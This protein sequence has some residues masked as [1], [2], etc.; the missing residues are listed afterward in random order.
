MTLQLHKRTRTTTT[1]TL[2][3]TNTLK[4]PR[5]YYI[6]G[7]MLLFSLTYTN[8]AT[9]PTLVEDAPFTLINKLR[10]KVAGWKNETLIDVTPKNFIS[11]MKLDNQIAPYYEALDTTASTQFTKTFALGLDFRINKLDRY[12]TLV[13]IPSFTYSSVEIELQVGDANDLASANPPT[14]DSLK[15]TPTLTELISDEQFDTLDYYLI[16]RSPSLSSEM[17]L[18]TGKMLRRLLLLTKDS[19]G[20]RSN[21]IISKYAVKVGSTPIIS[22]TDYITSQLMDREE[23]GIAPDTGVTIIDFAQINDI[24]NSLDLSNA[25]EGDIKLANTIA[26]TTGGIELLYN[27]IA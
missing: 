15:V 16:S 2:S 14:I 21:A 13:S 19:S 10:F 25:K 12:D 17:D 24:M 7:I 11:L 18:E 4:L 8:G 9:A 23:Y 5:D 1:L 6:Q 22:D 3:D 20:N 27:W 26:D